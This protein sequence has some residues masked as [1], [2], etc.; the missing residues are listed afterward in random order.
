M[1]VT[2]PTK[3]TSN[4]AAPAMISSRHFVWISPASIDGQRHR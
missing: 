2:G 4:P 3:V 1:S